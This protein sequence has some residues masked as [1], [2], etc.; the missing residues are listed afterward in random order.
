VERREKGKKEGEEERE[1][2]EEE[3]RAQEEA[4]DRV[5]RVIL[6]HSESEREK[7]N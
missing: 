4:N 6:L 2:E 1:K 5:E 7:S 3:L